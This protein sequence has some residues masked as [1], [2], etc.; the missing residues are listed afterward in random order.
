MAL[1]ATLEPVVCQVYNKFLINIKSFLKLKNEGLMGKPGLDGTPGFKG[2]KGER[3]L[4][5][6][7]GAPGDPGVEGEK[8]I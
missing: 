1:Q 6:F 7:P 8:I 3:G 2:D 4:D 5:G